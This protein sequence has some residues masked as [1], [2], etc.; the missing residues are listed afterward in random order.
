M[1]KEA[2]IPVK[3]DPMSREIAVGRKDKVIAGLWGFGFVLGVPGISFLAT[4]ERVMAQFA[5]DPGYTALIFGGLTALTSIGGAI[6]NKVIKSDARENRLADT[7]FPREEGYVSRITPVR[8]KIAEL[9]KTKARRVLVNSFHIKHAA[10]I[11]IST[12]Q[13]SEYKVVEVNSTH[14]INQY[15]VKEEG[16][17]LVEQEVIANPE[18]I[19]D[20]SAD[21]L[22]EV[23][24]VNEK[25]ESTKELA[26]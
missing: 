16:K 24:K 1:G 26:V 25:T 7:F 13:S 22:A 23:Y 15:L 8:Q 18:T 10:E 4:T 19:W 3:G 17:F 20:L 14:T 2:V 21:A 11:D 6:F 12:W 9:K 5:T